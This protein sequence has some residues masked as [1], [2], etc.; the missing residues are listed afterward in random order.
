[1]VLKA[2][3]IAPQDVYFFSAP[4]HLSVAASHSPPAF[5]HSVFVLGIVAS[6]AKTGPV[7]AMANVRTTKE[8][9]ASMA[10]SI[11]MLNC[12]LLHF[13]RIG[14]MRWGSARLTLLEGLFRE[15]ITLLRNLSDPA[16]IPI[17]HGGITFSLPSAG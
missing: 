10:L 14:G 9:R 11:V 12:R 16:G 2:T 3:H 15:F 4:M 1:M 8:T 17:D 6:P 13:L 7:A 5:S